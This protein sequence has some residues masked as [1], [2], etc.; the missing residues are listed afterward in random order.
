MDDYVVFIA[1]DD[2]S[3]NGWCDA[4]S[5]LHEQASVTVRMGGREITFSKTE[6]PDRVRMDYACE[7][8]LTIV[9]IR[10]GGTWVEEGG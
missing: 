4:A 2:V 3:L 7:P 6:D 5:R 10:V 9:M 1:A 8:K